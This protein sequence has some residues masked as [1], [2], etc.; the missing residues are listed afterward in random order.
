MPQTLDTSFLEITISEN[1]VVIFTS[2]LKRKKKHTF[3]PNGRKT[4]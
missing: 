1:E 3:I 2:V 4:Q